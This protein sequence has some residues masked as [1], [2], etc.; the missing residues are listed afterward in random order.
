MTN[1][2]RLNYL[3]SKKGRRID[4]LQDRI[5]ERLVS[6]CTTDDI[7]HAMINLNVTKAKEIEH[8]FHNGHSSEFYQLVTNVMYDQYLQQASDRAMEIGENEY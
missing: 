6:E 4:K 2:N 8:C 5:Q 1:L 7:G 3:G